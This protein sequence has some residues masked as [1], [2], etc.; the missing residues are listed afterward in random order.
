MSTS[1]SRQT[2]ENHAPKWKAKQRIHWGKFL[3]E[4]LSIFIAV[5]SA[6]AL[7][8][9][10]DNR[11]ARHAETNILKEI[12]NGLRLDSADV[13]LNIAG[14]KYGIKASLYFR[15]LLNNETVD[16]DSAAFYKRLLLRDFI[17]IQNTSGYESLKSQGLDIV[18]SD[19]L[20][21]EIISMYEYNYTLI[22]KIEEQYAA[23]QFF[24]RYADRF[25]DAIASQIRFDSTGGIKSINVPLKLTEKEK[26]H[27]LLDLKTIE[28]D[29][30]FTMS[31]YK[32]I[33]GQLV[34]TR[35]LID[36]ELQSR[37]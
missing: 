10:N 28:E 19:S 4:F 1:S 7:N 2:Q 14:H 11:K 25:N 3:V 22:E 36:K 23:Q 27:L 26:N 18:K 31:F 21:L 5:L 34:S 32:K 17:S 33:E 37:Y 29:R 24:E 35:T 9:W 20:R 13:A 12:S 8:N 16:M 15:R 30:R 6:F